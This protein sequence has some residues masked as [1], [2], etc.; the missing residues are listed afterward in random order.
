[1][2]NFFGVSRPIIMKLAP[3]NASFLA[4]SSGIL[5]GF[6]SSAVLEI[7]LVVYRLSGFFDRLGRARFAHDL[8]RGFF[9]YKSKFSDFATYVLDRFFGPNEVDRDE[10]GVY[11]CSY[12]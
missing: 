8:D 3:M 5:S 6:V 4:V 2:M 10:Y 9:P 11:I 7:S 12:G 1:M